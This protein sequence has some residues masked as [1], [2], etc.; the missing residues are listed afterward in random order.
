[1]FKIKI[2][3]SIP[4]AFPGM[5][6]YGVAA[7]ALKKGI[8]DLEIFDLKKYG[9]GLYKKIDEKPFGSEH[10]MIISPEPLGNCIDEIYSKNPELGLF[11]PC[12]WG[13]H[14]NQSFCK[15]LSKIKGMIIV[16]PRFEGVDFRIYEE[17][18][19]IIFSIGDFILTGGEIP[20]MA[21]CDS[22]IRLIDGTVGNK[23]SVIDDSFYSDALVEAPQYTRPRTWRNKNV[24][25]A[26]LNGNHK[27]I[28]EWK[29]KQ[30]LIMTK[31]FRPD[32]SIK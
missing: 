10:G 17:F 5:L 32:L 18:N 30:K 20:A 4:E 26:L 3:T 31:K 24:P 16:C 13:K 1:M 14:I 7:Q 6:N 19:P 22:V 2:I 27:I 21:L 28:N 15:E 11:I 9:K 29:E 23:E 25:E 8:W 12:A